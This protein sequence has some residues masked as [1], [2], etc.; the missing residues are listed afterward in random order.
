MEFPTLLTI[1]FDQ[2][3]GLQFTPLLT[4]TN[5]YSSPASGPEIPPSHQPLPLEDSTLALRF[6]PLKSPATRTELAKGAQT[7]A[8][9]PP[10]T[11]SRPFAERTVVR[12]MAT[13]E[14]KVRFMLPQ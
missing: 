10:G 5:L 8:Y 14:Q 11:S 3:S 1:S 12:A 7:R 4:T 9:A 2:G 13:K 6:Q